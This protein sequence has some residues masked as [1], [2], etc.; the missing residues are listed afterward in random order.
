M[1]DV[2]EQWR[3]AAGGADAVRERIDQ[4]ARFSAPVSRSLLVELTLRENDVAALQTVCDAGVRVQ[5]GL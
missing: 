3:A 4:L 2:V 5:R 1:G